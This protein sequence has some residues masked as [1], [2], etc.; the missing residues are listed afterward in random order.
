MGAGT[1]HTLQ[2]DQSWRVQLSIRSA[3][4]G[5]RAQFDV[6]VHPPAAQVAGL[7][8]LCD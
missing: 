1:E 2:A 8:S 4:V 6:Q 5:Q 3:C 7:G